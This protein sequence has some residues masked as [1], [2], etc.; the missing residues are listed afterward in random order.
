MDWVTYVKGVLLFLGALLVS[1]VLQ[2]AY[3]LLHQQQNRNWMAICVAVFGMAAA[4]H[5]VGS[6][7]SVMAG[8]SYNRSQ[9]MCRG[10]LCCDIAAVYGVLGRSVSQAGECFDLPGGCV[11][12]GVYH[13][14]QRAAGCTGAGLCSRYAC[15]LK[16]IASVG[17]NAAHGSLVRGSLVYCVLQCSI[18]SFSAK[19]VFLTAYAALWPAM[20]CDPRRCVCLV[21]GVV[22]N[23]L[24]CVLCPLD[25]QTLLQVSHYS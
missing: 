3:V 22:A 14:Q 16:R 23:T 24:Q 7:L 5:S 20:A 9:P 25:W 17:S 19:D 6:Q 2:V 1:A 4:A 11:S 10:V 21:D 15:A 8:I 13:R 12:E 18:C